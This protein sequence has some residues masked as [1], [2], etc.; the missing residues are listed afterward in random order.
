MAVSNPLSVLIVFARE[1]RR[2]EPGVNQVLTRVDTQEPAEQQEIPRQTTLEGSR[3]VVHLDQRGISHLVEKVS[4]IRK[5]RR[6]RVGESIFATDIAVLDV[7][8]RSQEKDDRIPADLFEFPVGGIDRGCLSTPM[9]E[10]KERLITQAVG[11]GMERILGC[12]NHVLMGLG[13][14]DSFVK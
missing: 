10:A 9:D 7:E 8:M 5:I 12:A 6:A 14:C 3:D 4:D 1:V 11:D 13:H 2:V